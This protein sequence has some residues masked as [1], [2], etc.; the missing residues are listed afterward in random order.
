MSHGADA[1]LH[2][3][4][5]GDAGERSG[6]HVAV[7]QRG[8]KPVALVRIVSQPVQQLGEAPL[9]RVNIAAPVDRLEVFSPRQFCDLPRLFVRAVIAPQVVVVERLH[10]CINRNHARACRIER[11]GS[12]VLSVDVVF[13]KCQAHGADQGLHLVVHAI[14]WRSQGHRVC[15]P[16]DIRPMQFPAGHARCPAA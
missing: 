13:F 9:M 5:I 1:A 10:P 12:D 11:N 14:A 3:R 7:F 15:A 2:L 4:G 8:G 16:E 6:D